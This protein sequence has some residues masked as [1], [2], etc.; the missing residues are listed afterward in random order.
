MPNTVSRDFLQRVEDNAVEHCVELA[1]SVA[2]EM[3]ND[4]TVY[5]DVE[6]RSADEFVPFVTDLMQRGV[7][8]HLQVIAPRFASRLMT[9]YRR[10]AGMEIG[11]R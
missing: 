7:M 10:E 9:R 3:I 1:L 6:F 4:G 5:G 11:I 2:D 8:D